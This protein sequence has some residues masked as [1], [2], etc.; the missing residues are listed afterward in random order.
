MIQYFHPA[1]GIQV[2]LLDLHE[3]YGETSQIVTDA[4]MKTLDLVSVSQKVVAFS[5]DNTNSNFG[6]AERRGTNNIHTKLKAELKRD[7]LLG[8]GCSAHTLHN[9]MQT[10]ADCLPFDVEQIVCKMYQH[11]SIYKVRVEKLKEFCEFADVEYKELLGYSKTRWLALMPAVERILLIFEGLKSYFLSLPQCPVV[12]KTFLDN[13]LSEAWMYFVHCQASRFNEVVTKVQSQLCTAMEVQIE[14]LNL[15]QVLQARKD[16]AFV[17]IEAKRILNKL[18]KDGDV[19]KQQAQEFV[20]RTL[21]FYDTCIGYIDRWGHSEDVRKLS[22]VLL[23]KTPSWSEVEVA[24]KMITNIIATGSSSSDGN[25]L[26]DQTACVIKYVTAYILDEWRKQATET[27]QR[28][29]EVFE[30]FARQQIAFGEILHV[31]QF[32]LALPGTNAPIERVFS[33]MNDNDRVICLHQWLRLQILPV[34]TSH[35]QRLPVR[36]LS[37]AKSSPINTPKFRN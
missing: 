20:A 16:E 4:I 36:S 28:W 37:L 27:G 15:R 13:P 19:T 24:S 2:K 23:R 11:F 17:G 32:A 8:L 12:I 25:N 26:F 1:K 33:L 7:A 34:W 5:A 30:N 14:F 9:A 22:F 29:V 31:V 21:S 3:L 35:A 10:G 6:G 18:E